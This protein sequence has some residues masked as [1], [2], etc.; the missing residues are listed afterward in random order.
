MKSNKIRAGIIID[1]G[2]VPYLIYDLIEKS[3][4]QDKYE[5]VAIF[6][7]H[8]KNSPKNIISKLIDYVSRRGLKNLLNL[9]FLHLLKKSKRLP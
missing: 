9:Y 7:Q 4:D 2:P 5:F 6:V 8:N 1:A 3:L